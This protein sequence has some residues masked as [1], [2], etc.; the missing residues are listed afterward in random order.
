[1]SGSDKNTSTSKTFDK[2]RVEEIFTTS[3]QERWPYPRIFHA[4]KDA[5]VESYDADVAS[6]EI[7]YRGHGESCVESSP[8]AANQLAINASFDQDG[9]QRAIRRNQSKQSNFAQFLSEIAQAGIQRY[10]VDMNARTVTYIGIRAEEYVE[11][12]PQF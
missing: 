7:I 3:K 12:V 11:K 1:M 5:G 4:L 2:K 6:H 8:H 9:V 10:R